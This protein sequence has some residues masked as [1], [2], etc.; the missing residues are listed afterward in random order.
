MALRN[1]RTFY[2]LLLAHLLFSY[3]NG[4]NTNETTALESLNS[5]EERPGDMVSFCDCN[6]RLIPKVK[7]INEVLWVLAGIVE[8]AQNNAAFTIATRPPSARSPIPSEVVFGGSVFLD[9]MSS[10]LTSIEQIQNNIRRIGTMQS[11]PEL[12]QRSL[13]AD[14]ELSCPLR[15]AIETYEN[16]HSRITE[17]VHFME[18]VKQDAIL[19]AES[20]LKI[21]Q[22]VVIINNKLKKFDFLQKQLESMP[23]LKSE[24]AIPEKPVDGRSFGETKAEDCICIEQLL[25]EVRNLTDILEWQ[26][27]I[28]KET[29]GYA[30]S[31]ITNRRPASGNILGRTAEAANFLGVAPEAENIVTDDYSAQGKYG[32]SFLGVNFYSSFHKVPAIP[33]E[34]ISR[35]A[36]SAPKECPMGKMIESRQKLMSKLSKAIHYREAVK[37]DPAIARHLLTVVTDA[38]NKL[39]K[40]LDNYKKYI[41]EL[42]TSD[43]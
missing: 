13:P 9:D 41:E 18:N 29:Q 30:V 3:T 5:M 4:T 19:A 27:L 33:S 15:P 1:L 40:K 24:E 25:P 22:T 43:C 20:L 28:L 8:E 23:C 38:I 39:E 12:Q 32:H 10:I 36:V 26:L 14:E 42:E 17:A 11:D 7:I 21:R 34:F 31:T 6:L 2:L 16:L 35:S 37:E